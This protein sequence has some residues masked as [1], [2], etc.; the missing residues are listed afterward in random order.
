MRPRS[1]FF[2]PGDIPPR[3]EIVR[4]FDPI[5]LNE[6]TDFTNPPIAHCFQSQALE[7]EPLPSGAR[8]RRVGPCASLGSGVKGDRECRLR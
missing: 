8:Q 2:D 5:G 4:H 3:S 7:V 1:A 6:Y